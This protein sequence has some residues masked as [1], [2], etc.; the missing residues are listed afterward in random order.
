MAHYSELAKMMAASYA[1]MAE[2]YGAS[3]QIV[4]SIVFGNS[5]NKSERRRCVETEVDNT[6]SREAKHSSSSDVTWSTMRI[7]RKEKSTT[8]RAKRESGSPFKNWII[9][10]SYE[11]SEAEVVMRATHPIWDSLNV[12]VWYDFELVPAKIK[13]A[14][15]WVQSFKENSRAEKLAMFEDMG[16]CAELGCLILE[17]SF[18][19]RGRVSARPRRIK[20]HP[21]VESAM[22][23]AVRDVPMRVSLDIPAT[24]NRSKYGRKRT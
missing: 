3:K 19:M 1:K 9:R 4:S 22:A 12:D 23:D 14:P 8:R 16:L 11:T 21:R 17:Y 5:E 2:Y 13:L 7:D 15:Y 6:I 18:P 10:G 20:L 24:M